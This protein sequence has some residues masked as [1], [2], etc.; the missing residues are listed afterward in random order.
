MN[1]YLVLYCDVPL[2]VLIYQFC[3]AALYLVFAFQ[4]K[5]PKWNAEGRPEFENRSEVAKKRMSDDGNGS[6]ASKRLK[7]TDLSVGNDGETL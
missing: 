5:K 3:F 2:H 4:K 6:S 1:T 7:S